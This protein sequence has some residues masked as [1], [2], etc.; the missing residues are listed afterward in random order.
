MPARSSGPPTSLSTSHSV[1]VLRDIGDS[2]SPRTRSRREFAMAAG[3]VVSRGSPGVASL[4]SVSQRSSRVTSSPM[5]RRN[6]VTASGPPSAS[7]TL[8]AAVLSLVRMV[9]EQS[10][11][12]EE[13][14]SELQSRENLVCRHLLEKK[15]DVEQGLRG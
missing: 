8:L 14:T 11:R 6:V 3:E 2:A 10:V 1:N 12:S 7:S 13:H 4:R 15:K 9:A 5:E